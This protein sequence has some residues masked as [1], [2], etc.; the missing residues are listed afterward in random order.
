MVSLLEVAL[1][2]LD[3][4]SFET[5]KLSETLNGLLEKTRQKPAILFSLIR[6]VTTWAPSSPGLVESLAVLGKETT[7]SRMKNAL[8]L[9]SKN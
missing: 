5:E 6:I 3:G 1:K 7:L 2:G 4:I 9:L 8:N